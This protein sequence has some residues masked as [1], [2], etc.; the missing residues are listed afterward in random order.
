MKYIVSYIRQTD[1]MIW[2]LCFLLSG[3]SLVLLMGILDSGYADYLDI[4]RRN[5]FIQGIS[6]CIGV[7]CAA[8]ISLIDYEDLAKMWKL[9]V[10]VCYALLLLTFFI[11][12]GAAERPD[13]KRWL[14][15]PGIN[16]SFQ[17]AELLRIS[18]ILA[19]AYHV[20]LVREHINHP[21]YLA[22]L[23]AHGITPAVLLHFQGDDGSALIFAVIMVCMLFSAGISWK[24]VFGALAAT[25]VSLPVI[26]NFILNE[27]QR[28]RILALYY[29]SA[30]DVQGYFYQQYW[31]LVA[32]AFGGRGGRGIFDVPHTYV[33]EMHNDFI[34]SFLGECMGFVGCL[35]VI[36]V[37]VALWLKILICAGRARDMFG[38]MICI[39]VFAMLS[40]QSVINIGM[41]ISVLPVIG[42]TLPFLSYGGS[43]VATSYFGIGLV[44]SVSMHSSKSIFSD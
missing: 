14:Q 27:F 12:T 29:R 4:S 42:N 2:M 44:L 40:F 38:Q 3:V 13:D 39:G 32:F 9:H 20:F 16:I 31:A 15:V 30:E 11:G 26:W 22:G 17:P 23:L 8:L 36:G 25:L 7:S 1:R 34:F 19:F 28:Q 18:F 35:F 33:P 43:S 6:A 24:Y 37:M 5:V 10:P 41:N 21:L